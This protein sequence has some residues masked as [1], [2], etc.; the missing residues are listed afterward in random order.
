M[1]QELRQLEEDIQYE[2]GSHYL[3]TRHWD[4]SIGTT[5]CEN[6]FYP[7]ESEKRELLPNGISVRKRTIE[8]EEG[9]WSESDLSS[10]WSVSK[11]EILGKEMIHVFHHRWLR[12][13]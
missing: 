3:R 6:W 5:V 12:D 7:V 8:M 1:Y 9:K 2:D 10:T 13:L 4:S 11:F